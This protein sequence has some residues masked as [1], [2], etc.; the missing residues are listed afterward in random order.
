MVN[1]PMI[2]QCGVSCG[3]I[4]FYSL[5]ALAQPQIDREELPRRAWFG[6]A[7]AP[8]EQGAVVT[9]VA[10]GSTAAAEGIQVGDVIRSVG[11][12]TVRT[13]EDVIAAVGRHRG[14]DTTT[15]GYLRSGVLHQRSRALRSFPR[16]TL[17]GV[18]FEY[19]SV[20]LR[21]G[22]RLRTVL[23]I[24]NQRQAPVPAVML[25]QGGGCG[26]IDVP[27]AA[28][29]GQ[30]GLIRTIAAQGYATMRVEKSGVGDSEG[31]SC[32]A[33][34]Y[35]EELEGYLSALATLKRHPSVDQDRVYLL[36][37]SLGGV[38]APMLARG[39]GI[40][41]IIVYG[42]LAAAPSPY[43]GRSERF[44]REFADVDVPA[45]WSTV[46]AHV[47]SVYGEFD[48]TAPRD[49]HARIAAVVNA[50]RPGRATLQE[51]P[52]LDHC[53]T[54]HETSAKSL[55]NC[56]NGTKVSTLADAILAFLTSTIN[57][58]AS[59]LPPVPRRS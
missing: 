56:G 13:P 53:W 32:A 43:P 23:S 50:R 51:L 49:H 27:M 59:D 34:G 30:P 9:A 44:F 38:F 25:I 48:E 15:I 4:L 29:V 12:T 33:I 45:A 40:K 37:I 58:V 10:E 47:L 11:A 26:S 2:R 14:G 3:L 18:T 54:R 16:E 7:L 1:Y 36:G 42:T 17:P 35:A 55:G 39:G 24:P 8:H 52:G 46:Q 5:T 28:D 31:L 19:G 57:R 41:G 21:D 6:V 22:S 20:T